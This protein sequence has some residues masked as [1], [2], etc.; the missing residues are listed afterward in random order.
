MFSATRASIVLVYLVIL[1]SAGHA[2]YP[3]YQPYYPP[4]GYGGFGPGNVLNGQANVINASGQLFIDQEKARVERETANQAKITT[5][6]KTFDEMMY[7]KAN[8]PTFTEDQSKVDMMT[9]RRLMNHPLPAE[10]TSG[11]SQNILLPYLDKLMRVGVQG[12][13]VS[14]D[15][16]MLK[17]INVTIGKGGA[18]IGLLRDGGELD[19]PMGVRG[20]TQKKL[21]P[22]FPKLVYAARNGD[23]DLALYTQASKGVTMLQDELGKKFRTEQIDAGLYLEG[24]HFLDSLASSVKMISSPSAAKL[25]NGT[26][27][28][29]G[30]TVPELVYNMTGKG[31]LFAPATPGNDAPYYA[32][33]SAMVSYAAGGETNHGFRETF[34]P[35]IQ[36]P[37]KSF[38]D[39]PPP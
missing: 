20:P 12:P 2:Q 14:L 33:Q 4:P 26:Y 13:P 16:T 24:K 5:K 27:A 1:S 11:K 15:P 37:K 21:A 3:P 6:R 19:W 18:N 7:E 31:L 22:L 30:R 9:I 10:I 29:T 25:L 17:S 23:L 28:A 35:F 39:I 32:L 8:T 36:A 38:A 34:D